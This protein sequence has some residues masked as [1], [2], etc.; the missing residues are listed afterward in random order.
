MH[1][2]EFFGGL[3]TAAVFVFVWVCEVAANR[4][5]VNNATAALQSLPLFGFCPWFFYYY[6]FFPLAV[7]SGSRGY[8]AAATANCLLG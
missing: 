4:V 7:R 2:P 5:C 1:L 6:Y 3:R 8:R